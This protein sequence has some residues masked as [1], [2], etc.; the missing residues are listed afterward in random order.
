MDNSLINKNEL[1]MD[2]FD[3]YI[4]IRISKSAHSKIRIF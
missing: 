4:K 1:F 2:N 3:I